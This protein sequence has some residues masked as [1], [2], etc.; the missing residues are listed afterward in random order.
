MIRSQPVQHWPS[1]DELCCLSYPWG[2]WGRRALL[3]GWGLSGRRPNRN[4]GGGGHR[5]SYKRLLKCWLLG[6][7][8]PRPQQGLMGSAVSKASLGP[9]A[10][11]EPCLLQGPEIPW[12][13]LT[14]GRKEFTKNRQQ[15]I[16][17]FL[18]SLSTGRVPLVALPR[19]LG[20]LA[21]PQGE[22]MPHDC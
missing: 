6:M 7:V 4:R 20:R 3:L 12:C 18:L 1:W 19:G 10:A 22:A 15:Q 14:T 11:P 5:H 2:L 16:L 8:F 21:E 13:R 17:A 9:H